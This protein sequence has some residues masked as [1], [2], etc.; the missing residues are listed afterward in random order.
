MKYI[1]FDNSKLPNLEYSLFKEILR[2]NKAGAYM[3]TSI[4][5][6]NTRKY[7]GLL[8]CPIEQFGN[9]SFVMLSSLQCSVI[10]HD[11]TFNLGIQQYKD[12]YFEPKGHKYM[13]DCTVDPTVK[14]T[15][16]V[17][18]V[19]LSQEFILAE[20]ENQVLIKYTLE[21]AHSDT[22][23]RLKPFLAFRNIHDLT[24]ENMQVN[25]HYDTVS[26]GAK[27]CLYHGFPELFLQT[28]KKADF[29]AMPDWYRDVEYIKERYRGYGYREDLYVPG[30]FEFPIKKGESVVFSASLKEA[31]TGSLKTK[32]TREVSRRKPSDS[33]QNLL[34]NAAAQFIER[35]QNNVL[36]KA[37]FHWKRPQMRDMFVALAGLAIYQEDKK[38]FAEIFE[39]SLPNLRR[40][41]IEQAAMNNTSIDVPLWFFYCINEME[42][43][44]P[45]Y[46][47]ATDHFGLMNDLLNHYWTGVPGKMH[48]Q[49]NGLIYAR[50]E[51]EPQT[52][53]NAKTSYGLIVT[54]RY[55]CAVEVNALWYN[56]IATTLEIAKK[57]GNKEFIDTWQPRLEQI[58]QAFLDT[59]CNEQ[60]YLFDY[61]DGDY[62][63]YTIRPNQLIAAG[64]RFSPLTREQK[65]NILD[66]ATKELLTP[67]GLRSL[68]PKD[69][70]YMG[71]VEGNQDERAL[72]L[73]QGTAYPW[74]LGFYADVMIEVHR[75]SGI[76]QLK[77]I[78]ADFESELTEH[79]IGTISE[80]YNGN[81][82]HQAKG[83]ISMAWNV[84]A[85]LK[86]MKITETK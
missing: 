41:Y 66:L 26:N 39:S 23:L 30:Y 3:S 19:V 5:G 46:I 28:S 76:A 18:G 24:Q 79:C 82:P 47:K 12:D 61:V 36:L 50:N 64:L 13:C 32:F 35:Q 21:D 25:T 81:P 17:G 55:G 34:I 22:T 54:P 45:R 74:L 80:R 29:V 8:V 20:N 70:K 52:W 62:K 78:V 53:M 1:Q 72:T 73:H 56:A 9:E 37:G 49:D 10:Q 86:L 11:K 68:T 67:R 63:S 60:G 44:L 59:F 48:R 6:C 42:R 40:L 77:R 69:D 65:K 4:L 85:L 84:A 2:T 38:T 43:F 83:A 57:L 14:V 27:F 33:M 58:G 31:A 7:H 71:A 16:R 75:N 51:G 15:H